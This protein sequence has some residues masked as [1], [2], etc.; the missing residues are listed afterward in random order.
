MGANGNAKPGCDVCNRSGLLLL[1]LRPSPVAKDY[2]LMPPGAGSVSVDE[3]G[4]VSGLVPATPLTESRYVLRLL[5]SGYV[6]VYIP[7]PPDGV[8]QW[9]VYR[10]TENADL[11]PQ[12]SGIFSQRPEPAACSRSGHNAA[13]M[14]LL[15]IPDAH[16][17]GTIWIAYS[18]NL[19][20]DRLKERNK[21]NPYAMRRVDLLA[22]AS[23]NPGSFRPT[24]QA[25]T[26]QVLEFA[27][28]RLTINN[29]RDHDFP[30]VS[31]HGREDD[32]SQ[33]MVTAAAAHPE[34]EGKEL[35]VVLSDPVGLTAE[36][37][38]LRLRRYELA[39]QYM[40]RPEIQQPLEV[41]K[42]IMT[43][44]GNLV[45]DLEDR[46]LDAVAPLRRRSAFEA[47]EVA[48]GTEWQA[49]TDEEM[50]VLQR[51]ASSDKG[52]AHALLTPYRRAYAA[53]PLGR[54][55]FPDHQERADAWVARETERAWRDM[56]GFYDESQRQQWQASFEA[57]MKRLHL[58][59]LRSY[60]LDWLH[61]MRDSATMECFATHYDPE[62]PND[63]DDLLRTGCS[64]GATY[65]REVAIAFTPEGHTDAVDS[66]MQRQ[67]DADVE[68]PDAVLLRAMAGNQKSL[69]DILVSDKRDKTYDFIKGLIGEAVETATRG[70]AASMAAG[71]SKTVS[72]LT[73]AT[74]GFSLGISG[75]LAAVAITAASGRF[76]SAAARTPVDPKAFGRLDR[77]RQVAL[78]H[79][80]SE[81][82]LSAA[83][84]GRAPK[85]PVVIMAN[86]SVDT[87]RRIMR[88]RGEP[89]SRRRVRQMARRGQVQLAIVTDA[90]AIAELKSQPGS[91]RAELAKSAHS[92]QINE[93]AINMRRLA[94]A[95]VAS[96]GMLTLPLSRFNT[97]YAAHVERVAQTPA[98]MRAWTRAQMRISTSPTA[99]A[100]RT[101]AV[102]MDGRLAMGGAIVQAIGIMNGLAAYRA[103]G[104]D[105]S[106][107]MDAW[108]EIADASAGLLGASAEL[109]AVAWAARVE[110]TAGAGGAQ[111]SSL[112]PALRGAAYGMGVASNV[113]CAWVSFRAAA[114]L[115][116]KGM[117]ELATVMRFS[118]YFFVAG[119]VPLAVASAHFFMQVAIRR[120]L[121]SAGNMAA[122]QVGR[123]VAA[124]LGTAA[125]G[126]SFPGVGWA[127]T[128]VAVGQTVYVAMNTLGPLQHWLAGCYFGKNVWYRKSVPKRVSWAQEERAFNAMQDELGSGQGSVRSE[129]TAGG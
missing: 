82:A 42:L 65:M 17:V 117:P 47:S 56:D 67:L 76:D 19:W 111:A 54:V 128:I 109:S 113:V 100:T 49:L 105:P 63:R 81:E 31:L 46:S 127:L 123:I 78:I 95:S 43:L 97:L 119:G 52:W 118:G 40:C 93:Q 3:N 26:G 75:T 9:H 86:C 116:A 120:G 50:E 8:A 1:L 59:P 61:A 20:G 103:A 101:T 106:R 122:R 36:L 12:T 14:R 4:L 79:A 2:T 32:F 34:T 29:A 99:Q 22:G 80:A 24:P 23:Q 69:I 37:N 84:R 39:E 121:M 33:Q 98:L 38:A 74:M 125:V 124:R 35:A 15:P 110:V 51:A 71:M 92:V 18:A 60:E 73:N 41:N 48:E 45:S 53:E 25:L 112:L 85:V 7:E 11:I 57:D 94:E 21:E 68:Q 72:W 90:D 88:S 114:K 62:D 126:L 107:Q 87:A 10:V 44:K 5:R 77:A 55:V 13:G 102:S 104:N 115:E 6:H 70:S 89:L 27:L 108:L 58:D 129:V 28:D 91:L 83:L 66:F 30:F 16:R 64:A 96:G